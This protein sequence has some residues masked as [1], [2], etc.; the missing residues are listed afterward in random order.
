MAGGNRAVVFLRLPSPLKVL[1]ECYQHDRG[2][3]SLN[4]A[5]IELLETHPELVNRVEL[6]YNGT[7]QTPNGEVPPL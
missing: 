3:L 5:V 6:F 2:L 1:A 4:A 7:S